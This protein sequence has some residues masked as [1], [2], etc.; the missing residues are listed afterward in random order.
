MSTYT[1]CQKYSFDIFLTAKKGL[2]LS[3]I[4][5]PM[6]GFRNLNALNE[7]CAYQKK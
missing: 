5:K 1:V 6:K 4:P 3:F 2:R 7:N